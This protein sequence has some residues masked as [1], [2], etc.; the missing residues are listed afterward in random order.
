MRAAD[1]LRSWV[2][3]WW[4]GEG[5]PAGDALT[6]LLAPAEAAF[7]VVSAAR[8]QLYDASVL[9]S[10][11]APIPVV[12]VG[13]VT[14]G[15]TGKTPVAAMIARRLL[16]G[17]RR[18][19]VV[20]RGYGADEVEVHRELN[21]TI[22]VEV[23]RR[24]VE[25]VAAAAAHGCDCA[26]LDDAF[27]HR[28]LRRDLDL[29]VVAAERWRPP[30]RLLPRGPWREPPAALLRADHLLVTRKTAD[31]AQAGRVI[32]EVRSLGFTGGSG[33]VHLRLGELERLEAASGSE[34]TA[35]AVPELKGG[36]FLAV[37][38]L[39]EPQLLIEQ[40]RSAGADV[41]LIAFPDHHEFTSAD[42]AAISDR[43]RST[44]RTL[45]MTRKEAVKLRHRVGHPAYVVSQ[46]VEVEKGSEALDDA[47]RRAVESGR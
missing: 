35:D 16:E 34:L 33:I 6:L 32:E 17:G 7:R 14:T 1:R 9:R 2:P 23:A 42:I 22:P 13:N 11:R 45:L 28:S 31:A 20:L 10:E 8:G 27:Q 4:A 37:T 29:V 12:S 26:V 15:G 21:P 30:R 24:R 18:P 3:R 19:A 44:S 46:A 40:L 36:R 39:A 38:T 43:V 47:I 5:G 41:E 25:G